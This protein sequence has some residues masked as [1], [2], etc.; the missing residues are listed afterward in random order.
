[1]SPFGIQ[2]IMPCFCVID[3]FYTHN[4]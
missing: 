4:L 1:L 3:Q 2:V